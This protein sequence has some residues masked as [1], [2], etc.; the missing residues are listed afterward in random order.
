MSKFQDSI[1][2]YESIQLRD[3]LKSTTPVTKRNAKSPEPA[4]F[5]SAPTFSQ[6]DNPF[7]FRSTEINNLCA[8]QSPMEQQN[9][10]VSEREEIV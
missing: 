9:H 6:I 1:D 8:K 7:G 4:A 3:M 5:V 10:S 2:N